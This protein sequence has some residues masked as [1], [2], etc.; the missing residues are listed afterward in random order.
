MAPLNEMKIVVGE[1]YAWILLEAIIITIHMF[2]TGMMMGLVRKRV[3]NKDFYQKKFPRYKQLITVMRPDGGYPD[4]G[5]GR[6]A[7]LLDDE[8]WFT[9]NNYRRAHMNYLEGGF[10]VLIPLLIS[11]LSYTRLTFFTGI[12][13]MIGR[14]L[15]SQGYR[16]TGS[17]GRITGV[18]ILDLALLMLW[19]MALYT[20]FYWG[21]GLH[22]LKRLIF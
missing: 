1:G 15:Y 19:S 14:E 8:E 6:L 2:L 10:A 20:C 16:R 7:D 18:I 21:N 4:D 12:A 13:Y 22:G 11:G 3:F 5:Q 17:K 9:L